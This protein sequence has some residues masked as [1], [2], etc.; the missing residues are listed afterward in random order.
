VVVRAVARNVAAGRSDWTVT[1]TLPSLAACDA[2]PVA[3]HVVAA[4][5]PGRSTAVGGGVAG[6]VV[7]VA[8]DP[9]TDG[10]VG[11]GCVVGVT[12]VC[13]RVSPPQPVRTPAAPT[14]ML[15]SQRPRQSITDPG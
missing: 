13:E 14:A 8:T 3:E 2:S 5:G 9:T 7:V 12:T 10:A 15:A 11:V 4:G 1:L 6:G